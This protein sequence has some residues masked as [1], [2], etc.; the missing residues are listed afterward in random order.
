[1]I[2]ECIK[3]FVVDSVD[4]NGFCIEN[5]GEQVKIG[6][7]WKLDESKIT[8]T[9]ADMRLNELTG[10]RWIEISNERL[11]SHFNLIN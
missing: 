11:G 2:Y 8:L 10:L 3:A 7:M 1:M 9:G 4:D 6:S 5:N